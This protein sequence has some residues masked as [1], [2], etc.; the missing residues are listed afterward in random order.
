M[1]SLAAA[2]I[3]EEES[4]PAELA[5]AVEN[6]VQSVVV[7]ARAAASVGSEAEFAA[8]MAAAGLAGSA[9]AVE[10]GSGMEEHAALESVA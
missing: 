8:P 6:F 2:E 5:A 10:F 4:A 9:A 1:S 3:V 7:V